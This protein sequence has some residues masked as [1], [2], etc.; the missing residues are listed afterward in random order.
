MGIAVASRTELMENFAKLQDQFSQ[1]LSDAQR[2]DQKFKQSCALFKKNVISQL[3]YS[4]QNISDKNPLYPQIVAF[5]ELLQERNIVW[6]EKIKQQDTGVHF[7]AGFNDS[8]LVFIY[9]KVK[10]GK[11]SLGNYMAWGN[12]DPT[13]ELKQNTSNRFHP[14]YFSEKQTDVSN[15]DAKKEAEDKREFRVGATEATSSIQGF[16]LPGLTWIDS[17]GLHSINA[18]NGD[19]AKEYVEHADLILYTMK[20]DSPGRDSDLQE[21]LQLYRADK[22][23]ILLVTGSDDTEADWDDE[24]DQPITRIIMKDKDRC[25]KQREYIR[26]A[27][28][29]LPGL[30]GTSENIEII[31]FSARYAQLFQDDPEQFLQSG[32][33]QLFTEI[34][35]V[36][37][38]EGV[39]IKQ[40]TPMKNFKYF[41]S[42]FGAD[43]QQYKQDLLEFN[44]PIERIQKSLPIKINECNRDI[45]NQMQQLIQNGFNQLETYRDDEDSMNIEYK[46]FA[47]GLNK[48]FAQLLQDTQMNIL[49]NVMNDFGNGVVQVIKND[50]L[51]NLPEFKNEKRTEHVTDKIKCGTKNRN[52]GIGALIGGGLGAVGGFVIG[53]PFGA[54]IGF[55]AGSA[56]GGMAGSKTGSEA[57]V[58]Y[59]EVTVKV[60]DNFHQLQQ[61]INLNIQKSITQSMKDFKVTL[62]DLALNNAQELVN[63]IEQELQVF[64]NDIQQLTNDIDQTVKAA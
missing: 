28:E 2:Q 59:R 47:S 3:D 37:Q 7:R 24:T 39:Q 49:N 8:L 13:N 22:K 56:L 23:I 44:Q 4:L 21:I 50:H 54:S 51:L 15:G 57:K 29:K 38:D 16:S 45:Q 33:G 36:A 52:S 60:G 41:L 40:Q 20:S 34:A 12:T 17:P 9:G 6:D 46:K 11:S 35:K 19:L 18:K 58:D 10:S 42:G 48:K 43:V 30:N 63:S 27:L 14:R 55:S 64:Q 61:E 31:S 62:L 1:A 53:G 25:F 26:T 32:M 5:K